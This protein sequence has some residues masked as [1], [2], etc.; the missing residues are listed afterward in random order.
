[1][2]WMATNM[3]RPGECLGQ[4]RIELS[5]LSQNIVSTLPLE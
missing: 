2:E 5:A 4:T 3:Q 1:M